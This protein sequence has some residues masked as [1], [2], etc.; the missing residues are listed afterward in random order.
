MPARG[1]CGLSE[2]GRHHHK[3]TLLVRDLD[4]FQRLLDRASIRVYFS[5]AFADDDIARAVEPQAPGVTTRFEAMKLLSEAGIPT[6]ISV[7]PI[8]PGLNDEAIPDLLARAKAAGATTA[9][10]SVLRLPGNVEPVFLERMRDAFPDRISRLSTAFK[11]C[12]A[13]R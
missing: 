7:A 10:W 2:S 13:E 11:R 1:L 3:G 8:I 12:E 9:T 4:L 5:I 6:G